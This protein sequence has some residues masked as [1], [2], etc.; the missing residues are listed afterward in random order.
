MT[1]TPI[2]MTQRLTDEVRIVS[3]GG[4]SR[5][6]STL[7][8]FMLAQLDGFV[9]VGE[10]RYIWSRGYVDNELCGCG[11][12]FHECDFWIAVLEDA[13]GRVDLVPINELLALHRSVAQVW[14]LPLHISPKRPSEFEFKLD[15]YI[16]H[17]Q[18]ICRAILNVTGADV[19]VDSSKLPSYCYLLTQLSGTDVQLVHLVR[20]SRAVAFSFMRKRRKPEIRQRAAYMRRFSPVR[21]ARD[22]DLLN[23]GMEMLRNAKCRYDFVRYEDLVNDP[24]T[25]LSRLMRHTG[26][27]VNMPTNGAFSLS[28]SHTV[29]GNPLRFTQ[30]Q[31]RIRP[32][33]EWKE[34]MGRVEY[35]VVT[36]LTWPLLLR[37]GYL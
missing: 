31:I 17:L 10:L 11:R 13:Y 26:E 23:V 12:P 36:A 33:T 22:W 4:A 1:Q 5:S 28:T 27:V 8:A 7:L 19:I 24:G 3:V 18:R 35:S 20:D 2:V 16:H 21:S 34:R 6:G 30:D 9:A 29:A 14:Q 15:A 32:D 37:Y 25:E